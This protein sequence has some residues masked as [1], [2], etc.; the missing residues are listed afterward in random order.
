MAAIHST[1]SNI[2]GK[3]S[4]NFHQTREFQREV[5]MSLARA[6][7]LNSHLILVK[8][9]TVVGWHRQGF[10]LFSYV[11][12][13]IG[14]IRRDCVDRMIVFGE[15][16]LLSILRSYQRYYNESRCHFSK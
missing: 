14:S 6:I 5:W 8:P 1:G 16:H 15:E 12:R 10:K 13:V 2:I 4:P 3:A 9:E 11:E 7:A